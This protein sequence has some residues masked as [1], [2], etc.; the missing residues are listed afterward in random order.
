ML[1]AREEA[2]RRRTLRM[3]EWLADPFDRDADPCHVTGSAIVVDPTG[4]VLLHRHVRLGRWLQP[5]GHVERG[6]DVHEAARRETL[7]ETGVESVHPSSGPLLLHVD[8]H[9]GPLGHV[10]LDARWLLEVPG[11][12]GTRPRTDAAWFEPVA[13]RALA[14][15]SLDDA[16]RALTLRAPRPS[17]ER[18]EREDRA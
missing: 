13:A 16:L 6:E 1:D 4:R 12:T 3:L 11:G 7:E 8:V 9:E 18:A 2:A 15:R 14:D 17:T 10:H 5:G